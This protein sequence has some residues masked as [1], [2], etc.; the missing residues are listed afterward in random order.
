MSVRWDDLSRELYVTG[1]PELT[2]V[3][4]FRLIIRAVDSEHGDRLIVSP[5]TAFV[6]VPSEMAAAFMQQNNERQ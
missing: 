3:E 5:S 6:D 4:E 1:D 2:E